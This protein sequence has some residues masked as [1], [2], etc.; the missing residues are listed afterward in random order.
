MNALP[1]QSIDHVF[2]DPPY[3]DKEQYGEINF[4]WEAWLGFDTHWHDEEIIVNE[5]RGMAEADWAQRMRQAMAECYRVLKPGRW[6]TLCYHDTSEGTWALVQ[7]L[8][9]EVGFIPDTSNVALFI[10]TGQKSYNQLTADKVTKRDMVI[11]FRKPRPG[12]VSGLVI[13]GDEDDTTFEEKVRAILRDYL[14]THPGSTKDRIYDELVSRMVRAGQMQKHNFDALL[15]AVAE[16]VLE[17]LS[18]ANS[19][20]YMLSHSGIHGAMRWYLRETEMEAF[21][22]AETAREDAA[23]ASVEAFIR[24]QMRAEP[25]M[26]GVDY[27]HIFEHFVHAVPHAEMPRRKLSEW[28]SDYFTRT[29]LGLWQLP[30]TEEERQQKAAGRVAGLGRRVRRYLAL[31]GSGT[32]IPERDQPTDATLAEWIRHCKNAGMYAQGI[33][34]YERG[35]LRLDRLSEEAQVLVE[36]DYAICMR[37]QRQTAEAAPVRRAARKA[38]K[39]LAEQS[40]LAFGE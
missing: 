11:N 9:A 35:G 37:R 32:A 1:T 28:L 21:D 6:L 20:M 29:T 14:A 36:E 34:L 26:G 23:A 8:M 40:E 2:T 12:E 13:T 38:K 5:V 7:D 27:S 4:V 19:I 33:E 24:H 39:M 10:D 3:A 15:L 30:A 16:P 18:R 22:T 31:L 25:E 17:T